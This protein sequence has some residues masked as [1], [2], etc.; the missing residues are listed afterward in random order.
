[1]I[2][3]GFKNHDAL[4][5]DQC[6][7]VLLC[8][9]LLITSFVHFKKKISANLSP[10]LHQ[11]CMFLALLFAVCII[12]TQVSTGFMSPEQAS[13]ILLLMFAFTLF[14]IGTY[15]DFILMLTGLTLMIS[16]YI[17]ACSF[18]NM[19]LVNTALTGGFFVLV[20]T[21]NHIAFRAIK[22]RN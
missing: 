22:N 9:A 13:K 3:Y 20:I 16:V 4:R 11:L 8:C 10:L 5:Y 14:A 18:E 17:T 21:Y 6:L 15:T 2:S 19:I 12:Q 1:M 7:I